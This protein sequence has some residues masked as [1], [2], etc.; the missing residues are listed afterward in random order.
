[1]IVSAA[2]VGICRS[3]IME[4]AIT[5]LYRVWAVSGPAWRRPRYRHI[6]SAAGQLEACDPGLP[7]VSE[8]RGGRALDRVVLVDVPERAVVNRVHGHIGVVTPARVH[9]R[10]GGR[11]VDDRPFA[12]RHLTEWIAGQP[13]R[14]ANAGE[15]TGGV[16]DAVAERCIAVLVG[17]DAAHPAVDAVG[18]A[19]DG[20]LLV[21]AVGTVRP[22]NLVP[23]GAGEPW[24]CL[25][26][27]VGE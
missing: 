22:P 14:V 8:W 7:A 6:S 26:R 20:A 1:M 27:L 13:A 17:G 16:H 24:R 19:G 18:G 11:A 10:L 23:P 25:H 12:E 5:R 3:S 15:H 9:V 21:Q 2:D 4:T